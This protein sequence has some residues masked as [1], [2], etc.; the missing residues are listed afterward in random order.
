MKEKSNSK[1]KANSKHDYVM[2][3]AMRMKKAE[4]IIYSCS[5]F[6]VALIVQLIASLVGMFIYGIY[7]EV[8]LEPDKKISQIDISEVLNTS[9]TMDASLVISVFSAIAC[10]VV[11]LLWYAQQMKNESST[12]V[13][14][15]MK[16]KHILLIVLLGIALQVG[17]SF[18]LN[19]I[20]MVKP[21]WFYN[22]GLIIEQLGGGT[23]IVSLIYIVVIAPISE[24]LIFRGVLLNKAKKILPLLWA[25]VLQAFLFGLYHMNMIQGI[26]AFIIGISL[27][28]IC[29][30]FKSIYAAVALHVII[31]L[32]G[33]LLGQITISEQYQTPL[34]FSGIIIISMVGIIF[35]MIMLKKD[36][37]QK[38]EVIVSDRTSWNIKYISK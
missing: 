3:K 29:N 9:L 14:E 2:K 12:I 10:F 16:L 26:Y 30:G 5:P 8:Q 22:Y 6:V 23:S 24:E 18:M 1:Q 21:S 15:K 34:V 27:G 31:N 7:M 37:N 25:N 13:K 20:A 35:S 4:D 33:L 19:L 38:E 36:Y 28:S 17:F 32:C 11:F